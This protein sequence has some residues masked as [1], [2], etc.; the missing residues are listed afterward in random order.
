MP[1]FVESKQSSRALHRQRKIRKMYLVIRRKSNLFIMD[2]DGVSKET[3]G[4]ND[5][6][7]H[8]GIAFLI[9]YAP[10]RVAGKAVRN[11]TDCMGIRWQITLFKL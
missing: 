7:F 1:L 6:L 5:V 10:V 4:K 3:K 2:Q 9:A 8:F 11:N